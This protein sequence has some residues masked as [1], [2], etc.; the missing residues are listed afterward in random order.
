VLRVFK[1][2]VCI[3]QR[4]VVGLFLCA[5]NFPPRGKKGVF[6]GSGKL[7]PSVE[8]SVFI[9]VLSLGPKTAIKSESNNVF[10]GN[11]PQIV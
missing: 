7:L 4:L 9:I 8:K 6:G 3:A 1:R 11:F 10:F 2:N 5:F